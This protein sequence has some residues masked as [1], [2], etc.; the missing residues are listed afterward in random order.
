MPQKS[1]INKIGNKWLL[2]MFATPG[3]VLFWVFL[4]QAEYD[5]KGY[6]T[7]RKSA[8]E[9]DEAIFLLVAFKAFFLIS[10]I[11]VL[12]ILYKRL[13]NKEY[14]D[15]IEEECRKLEPHICMRCKEAFVPDES[16]T[17]KYCGSITIEPIK[18]IYEKYPDLDEDA[19]DIN[20]TQPS[21][22]KTHR[23]N[24]SKSYL[25][26]FIIAWS[27]CWIIS[28]IYLLKTSDSFLGIVIFAWPFLVITYMIPHVIKIIRQG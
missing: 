12:A 1:R 3:I 23:N 6:I 27:I 14:D 26:I 2:T 28:T 13:T 18:G 22:P 25:D 19:F 17:C 5:R 7:F 8:F 4:F 20:N 15:R 16:G 10:L 9:G 11:Y 24:I 21:F